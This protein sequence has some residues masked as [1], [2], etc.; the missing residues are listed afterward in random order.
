MCITSGDEPSEQG[1]PSYSLFLL[2][3]SGIL[4][5]FL[6]QGRV[7][8]YV[9]CRAIFIAVDMHLYHI[10]LALLVYQSLELILF[11]L[12]FHQSFI[13]LH[14]RIGVGLSGLPD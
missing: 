7:F 12:L 1:W 10:S 8:V 4:G 14:N 5:G 3:L 9:L 11:S 2:I 13:F 6:L